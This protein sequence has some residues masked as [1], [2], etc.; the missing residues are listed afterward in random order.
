MCFGQFLVR[1][2][3][4]CGACREIEPEALARL[5]G[6]KATLKQLAHRMRCSHC[7]KK[8]AEV[9]AVARQAARSA[10]ESAL[11][12]GLLS[13]Q[14]ARTVDALAALFAR[15]HLEAVHARS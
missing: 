6:W 13:E 10:E 9:V 14:I 2:V 8:A 11:K 3:C 7:G 1:V 5:V 12:S 15:Q 4:D